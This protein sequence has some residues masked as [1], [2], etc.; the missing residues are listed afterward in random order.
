MN[1]EKPPELPK[2]PPTQREQYN[3]VTD[4]VGGPNLRLKDN[5]YQGIAIVVCLVLGAVVGSFLAEER[6]TG[7]GIGALVGLVAGTLGSGIFL[8][9]YRAVRHARGKHD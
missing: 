5:L 1:E 7:A 4:T 2:P 6:M 8:M 3:L 9:V